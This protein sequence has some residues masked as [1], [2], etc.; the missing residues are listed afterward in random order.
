MRSYLYQSAPM[1]IGKKEWRLVVYDARGYLG[2]K[3]F[4]DY[5]WREPAWNTLPPD[6]WRSMK[7][8]PTYD[9]NDGCW[10]GCPKTLRKLWERE[11]P[12]IRHHLEPGAPEPA[13]TLF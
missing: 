7:D 10:A 6:D 12:A 8:W 4:T 3:V 11:F 13:P 5:E 2:A 9:H 1:R